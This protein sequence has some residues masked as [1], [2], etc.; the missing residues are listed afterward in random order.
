MH[1][2]PGWS[3]D[4]VLVVPLGLVLLVYAVGWARLSRR[5]SAKVD[6][7]LFL[8]GWLVLA[9]AAV[10]P[11]H[12]AGELSFT[13]HMV[14]HELIMLVATL[15]LAASR[16]GAVLA[17]GLPRPL[18]LALAGSW[19]S[20]VQAIWRRLTEPVTA[21]ALQGA[22]MWIWHAPVLFNRALQS[23]GWHIAQHLSFFVTA[24]LFWWA[25]LNPRGRGYGLS[26]AC[27]FA[28]SLIGGALGALMSFSTSPWYSE[29]AAMGMSGIGLDPV[30]D[31]RLAG[32][33]M[34]VPGGLVH[35]GA[36]LVLCYKWLKSSEGRGAVTLH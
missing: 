5:A 27:L 36:A 34:W 24:L 18:R 13:W 7:R 29:Y 28:T 14:E 6:P 35:A 25:M 23:E 32:L 3:F 4:P 19:K 15:L 11:L 10:S 31:Q 33:I 17:W 21:T 12:E 9:L 1:A 20:P 26:A 8:A 16:A 22:V 30:D 2:R